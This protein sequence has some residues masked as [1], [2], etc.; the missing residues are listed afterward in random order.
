MIRKTLWD[1]KEE[2]G[3]CA[4]LKNNATFNYCFPSDSPPKLL[5]TIAAV[6]LF[7]LSAKASMRRKIR[8]M[9]GIC[10]RN[11]S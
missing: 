10:T 5:A 1:L 2:D 9:P 7:Q 11:I 3:A 6:V 4:N 8:P